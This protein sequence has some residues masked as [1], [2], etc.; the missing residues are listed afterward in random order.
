MR[1]PRSRLLLPALVVVSSTVA[2]ASNAADTSDGELTPRPALDSKRRLAAA[3]RPWR[4]VRRPHAILIVLDELPGDSLLDERG[5]V[6]PVRY[7]NFAALAATATWF[8]NAYSI[9]DSTTKAVPAILDGMLPR[10]GTAPDRRDHPRSIFDMFARRGYR[11]VSSEEA[12][13]L[14][15]PRLCRGGRARRPA[16]LPNLRR[17]RPQR[18]ARFVRTIRPSRRPTFWMKHVLLPHG[19][20]LYLP[21]GARTRRGSTDLLPGMLTVPGFH[22]AFLTR[23]NEQRYLLQLGFV[24]RLLGRMLRRLRRLDMFDDT[25]IVVTADHGYAWQV[26]VDTRRSVRPSNVEELAPVPLIVKA[27]GQR[28]GRIRPAYARTVD[29]APTIADVLGFRL[30]YRPDGRSAFSRAVRRRRTITIPTRDFDAMVQISGRRWEARRRLVA[31]RRLRQLGSG[32]WASLYTGIGPNR[33]LIGLRPAAPARAAA[34]DGRASIA[35]APSFGRVRR[36][37]GLVPA[38]IA[39]DL[40]ARVARRRR[41]VAVA[42]NG[43]IEAVG[44]SFYLAGDATEHFAVMVPEESL[45]EGRNR[46]EVFEV[47]PGRKLLLLARSQPRS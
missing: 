16:I 5:R 13:A 9:Y 23:H 19:P 33:S 44:R 41:D 3:P 36:A 20:Y 26:G 46:V 43:R 40:G 24:D 1:A 21:S 10:P 39:G 11:I 6:D 27:P 12:T 17:G 35:M 42:V 32:E 38:Q 7:P 45:R 18:F 34:A 4:P 22:D 8:K 14:C 28:W 15:P 37:A 2:F 29:V 30:G 25:L 31:R 47:T